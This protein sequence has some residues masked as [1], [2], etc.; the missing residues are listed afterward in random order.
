VRWIVDHQFSALA[1]AEANI[2]YDLGRLPMTMGHLGA[3]LLFVRSGA[4]PRF[5]RALGAVG[6]MALSSYLTHSIVCGILF[7]G[8]GL[9]GQLERHQLYYIVFAIWAAQ[10]VISPIWLSHFRFG[11][12]EWLWRDLTY[13][14]RPPFRRARP[15]AVTA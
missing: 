6:Q 4:L 1:F 7:V 14:R 9:Y 11:P 10:L 12:A 15:D 3:L 5:R 8:L 2:T 13:L